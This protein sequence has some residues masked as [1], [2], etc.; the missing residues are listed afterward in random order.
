MRTRD[1]CCKIPWRRRDDEEF[2]T[3]AY[4]WIT[5]H[6]DPDTV[7]LTWRDSIAFL[8]TGVP[9]SRSLLV[10]TVRIDS[11]MQ[12]AQPSQFP[13]AKVGLAPL[14]QLP[15]RYR[16]ALILLTESEISGSDRGAVFRGLRSRVES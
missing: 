5:Q 13:S 6:A 8:H 1:A 3:H 11:P 4:E 12:L 16:R 15:A 9:S 14:S 10:G 7:L 2:D